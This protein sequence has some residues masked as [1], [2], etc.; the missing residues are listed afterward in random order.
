M[1]ASPIDP[2]GELREL[3]SDCVHCGFCLPACPTYQLW[4]EEMDSPRGRIHLIT[5]MLDGTSASE[6]VTAHLDRCLGCMACVPACPSGVRYDRLIESARSWA[7]QPPAGATPL[8]RRSL[9]ARLV[10]TAIFAT[11]P[12]PRRL[13]LLTGPLRIAQ[14]TGVNRRIERSPLAGR[15]APELVASLRVAPA[16]PPRARARA[17]KP[18]PGSPAIPATGPVRTGRVPAQGPRRAVVGM[19]TGCVQQVFFPGVNDATVRVLAAEGCDVVIPHG[20]GCCGALS[21]HTGRLAE[22]ARFARRTIA[23]FEDAGVDVIVVNSAG[24]GSAMK[25]YAGLFSA[26]GHDPAADSAQ[27]RPAAP[28]APDAADREQRAAPDAAGWAQRAARTASK[29]RDLSEFLAEL[30][31]GDGGPR[32]VRHPLPV[33]AVYHEACHLG[34]A[35]GI[36]QQPRDLLRAIPGL[37]LIELADGGT[38]CGSAGVYNLLQPEAASELGARK[39]AAVLA[40]GAPLVISANPGCSLQIAAAMAAAGPGPGAGGGPGDGAGAAP[41]PVLLHI[42]EVLDASLRGVPV[43]ALTGHADR[44]SQPGHK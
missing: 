25:E 16:P 43:A 3:A 6:A 34:H 38:C 41:R 9:R 32:A 35:Q 42:A 4:G 22:A 24:C 40:T 44:D 29:V 11:F 1:S 12:Y 2:S 31:A 27:A 19:L 39:A 15:L 33:P 13:R 26:A 37:E 18:P 36:R 7:E 23:A 28:A 30:A 14:R 5:Q 20:Q 8:P 10:R 21:L 17:R